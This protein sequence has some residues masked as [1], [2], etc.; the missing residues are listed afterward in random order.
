MISRL[1]MKRWKSHED[2]ELKFGK[3]SNLFIGK[4]GSGKSSAIDAISFA[5]FGTFPALKSRR[6][7]IEELVMQRPN[8]HSSA[9]IE[10]E[11]D[12][13][14]KNYRI[15][16]QAGGKT[17]SAQLFEEGKLIEAQTSR[18]SEMVEGILKIDYDLFSRIIYAEQNRIDY[19]L[20][21]QKGERKRQIDELLGIARFEQVR[22]NAGTAV[23][24][25]GNLKQED[26]KF[27][28]G[29]GAP[30]LKEERERLQKEIAE[31]TEMMRHKQH[32]N[33]EMLAKVREIRKRMVEK[34]AEEGKHLQ[35]QRQL[36]ETEALIKDKNSQLE[37]GYSEEQLEKLRRETAE[38]ERKE[39]E[40]N[41]ELKI[42]GNALSEASAKL[43]M[44]KAEV[45]KLE[46]RERERDALARKKE[47]LGNVAEIE[48][49][50]KKREAEIQGYSEKYAK[51]EAELSEL[52]KSVHA[53]H[54][55][56]A[57][58]PVCDS[59]ITEERKRELIGKREQRKGE[60]HHEK[61]NARKALSEARMG[62]EIERRKMLEAKEAAI[63]LE[64][65]EGVAEELKE[66]KGK[67]EAL[68]K[69]EPALKEKVKA[70]SDGLEELGRKVQK[71]RQELLKMERI[72]KLKHEIALLEGKRGGLK[73]EMQAL[74]FEPTELKKLRE[75]I[76]DA[77]KKSSALGAEID[78]VG[79]L[80]AT[81]N[82]N[83]NEII[84][85]LEELE[86]KEAEINKIKGKISKLTGFQEAVVETQ[87]EM[88]QQLV[89][90]MNSAM[91]S[92]WPSIYP[93]ND[94]SQVR[95][96]PTEDD[97]LLELKTTANE[98]MP[99]ESGSGGEKSCAALTL[100]VAFAM[101]LTPNL[102]WLILDEPT[103]NLDGQ[104]VQLLNRALHDEIPKIVEQ[105][106]IITHDEA[107]KEG[108]SSKIFYFERDKDS[109]EKSS[110][111]E[112]GG[113]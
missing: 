24:K 102:S 103:H 73:K 4:M 6:V 64:Q 71:S 67:L 101:V 72:P 49:A 52:E 5:L 8:K 51:S 20:T 54:G 57:K 68:M 11:F 93:Y 104:A 76:V 32:E 23:G 90:A 36:G 95:L 53:L 45:H 35:L 44:L 61:E 110:V 25:L 86:K 74:K 10:L 33:S 80:I 14:G 42:A 9:E 60:L 50:V 12:F 66:T 56:D 26:E 75:G 22:A 41:G 15:V 21:L 63:K 85:R 83:V 99:I 19:L 82:A 27:L 84:G 30:K 106:F 3:G 96:S 40:G 113:N 17:T 34:E 46:S 79:S 58:C 28:E 39:K 70:F 16:R 87:A 97:Y 108:A 18:V 91:N 78:S 69:E 38:L 1:R 55:A 100:R 92:L 89:D 111:E 105:T 62:V 47:A 7:K 77:E 65:F 109:G 107:L 37:E 94:Y 81:K 59:E 98:W 2:T 112:M 31:K 13:G 43:G 88:R 48:S 29:A